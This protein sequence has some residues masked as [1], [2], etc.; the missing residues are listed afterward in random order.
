VSLFENSC[1]TSDNILIFCGV[2]HYQKGAF[3][4]DNMKLTRRFLDVYDVEVSALIK[5]MKFPTIGIGF[6]GS[7][8][9]SLDEDPTR[10]WEFRL[11]HID[12]GSS[13]SEDGEEIMARIVNIRLCWINI[14]DKPYQLRL[15]LLALAQCLQVI[16]QQLA[17]PIGVER[18]DWHCHGGVIL[19]NKVVRRLA[20][21]FPYRQTTSC[22]CQ[23]C[24][25][26]W[27]GILRTTRRWPLKQ[28][29]DLGVR[30]EQSMRV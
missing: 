29:A 7:L 26:T 28:E 20:S 4:L 18:I 12:Y 15:G 3:K 21:L 8:P 25:E 27:L 19:P 24:L 9:E 2:R 22:V 23:H 13:L 16:G 5:D 17:Q 11:S 30:Y 10:L 1:H 14:I 6:D